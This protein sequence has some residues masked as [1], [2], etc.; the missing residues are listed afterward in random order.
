MT[1]RYCKPRARVFKVYQG[2]RLGGP[3]WAAAVDHGGW[4]DVKPFNTWEQA[5]DHANYMA[6]LIRAG[7]A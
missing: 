5:M 7:C 3:Y 4:M 1:C 2:E 6:Y